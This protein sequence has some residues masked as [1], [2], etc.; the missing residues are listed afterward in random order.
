MRL[1]EFESWTEINHILARLE[2]YLNIR[3]NVIIILVWYKTRYSLQ[4]T[5]SIIK[6]HEIEWQNYGRVLLGLFQNRNTRNR[7]YSCSSYYSVFRMSGISFCS[8]CSQYR[9]NTRSF[10]KFLVV[11]PT[12]LT[13]PVAV[14][15]VRRYSNYQVTSDS[16]SRSETCRSVLFEIEIPCILLFL[17]RNKNS[18]N[19]PKRM[20]TIY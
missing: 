20:H 5:I 19:S 16:V 1:I 15:Y 3:W 9:Q 10:G 11:N 18:Q 7:Q 2:Q 6:S 12:W 4:T 8:F 14:K 13:A 17:N